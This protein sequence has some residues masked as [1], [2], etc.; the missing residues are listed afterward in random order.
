[1]WVRESPR[2]LVKQGRYEDAVKSL[3]WALGENID[4]RNVVLGPEDK[5]VRT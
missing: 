1:M 4:Y 3:N 2:W 5:A